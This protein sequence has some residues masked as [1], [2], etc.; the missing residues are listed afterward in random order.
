MGNACVNETKQSENIKEHQWSLYSRLNAPLKSGC[1]YEGEWQD[2]KPN[3]TGVAKWPDG[4]SFEGEFV[5]GKPFGGNL[6]SP[7]MP[8][9]NV[10]SR[11]HA[12]SMSSPSSK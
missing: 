3:G 4:W 2:G 12:N 11:F 1:I 9:N 10:H 6:T 8:D 5:D 7:K